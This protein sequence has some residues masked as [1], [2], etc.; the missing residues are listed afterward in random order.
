MVSRRGG[1]GR[2][3]GVDVVSGKGERLF[4]EPPA[5]ADSHDARRRDGWKCCEACGAELFFGGLVGDKRE[6]LSEMA[7]HYPEA[8]AL[9]FVISAVVVRRVG[10]DGDW[11]IVDKHDRPIEP[12]SN[13]RGEIGDK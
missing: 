6:Q 10:P 7:Q 8:R 1:R 2:G 4:P 11:W 9:R 3:G 5:C 13:K 12:L